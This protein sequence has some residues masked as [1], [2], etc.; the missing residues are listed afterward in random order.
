MTDREWAKLFDLINK[1]INLPDMSAG[2]KG[3][4]IRAKAE[5]NGASGDL[6]EFIAEAEAGTQE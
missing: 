4:L 6:E 2:E 5:E 3:A 1:A